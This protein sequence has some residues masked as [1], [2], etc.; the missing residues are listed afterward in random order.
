[1]TQWHWTGEREVRRRPCVSA[2]WEGLR[3]REG[4]FYWGGGRRERGEARGRVR[5]GTRLAVRW[6][7]DDLVIG[8]LESIAAR[9]ED[10]T[11]DA[12]WGEG[13]EAKLTLNTQMAATVESER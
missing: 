12:W 6:E 1:M 9:V 3:R 10:V 5:Q 4:Q 2:N 8:S 13:S 7:G 11:R